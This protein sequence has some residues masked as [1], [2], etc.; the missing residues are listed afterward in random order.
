LAPA[1][2]FSSW[3]LP[4]IPPWWLLLLL[5]LHLP[6]QGLHLQGLGHWLL[7]LLLVAAWSLCLHCCIQTKTVCTVGRLRQL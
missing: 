5:C 7:L 1:L 4:E 6:L 2:H 3:A